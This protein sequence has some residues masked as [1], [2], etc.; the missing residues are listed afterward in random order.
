MTA[1]R[2]AVGGKIRLTNIPTGW[3]ELTMSNEIHASGSN[4]KTAAREETRR[5]LLDTGFVL[6]REKGYAA[7]RV[8]DICVLAGVTKGAFFH[9]FRS[10]EDWAAAVANHWSAVTGALFETAPYHAPSDPLDRF[11]G[12]IDFRRMILDGKVS[13][14]TCVVGTLTQEIHMAHPAILEAAGKSIF[15]HADTLVP[16]IEAARAARCPDAE[17]K[18]SSL[19][20]FTQATLQGAF[21]LAKARGGP[22]IARDMVDHLR[23][24]VE[25]LF[26]VPHGCG[27]LQS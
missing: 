25:Q 19:A 14:F 3:Y 23:R 21:I 13:E 7:T 5:K 8:D 27:G 6:I 1:F 9:H 26:G 17:W 22:E 11:L 4:A 15:E 12:Y 24:Y 16:D 10:K 20:Q 18:P 2:F